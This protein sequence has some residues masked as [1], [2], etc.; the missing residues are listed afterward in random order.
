VNLIPKGTTVQ[1]PYSA[2]CAKSE[3]NI[4]DSKYTGK[5]KQRRKNMQE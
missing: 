5:V 3:T 1:M 4:K 2:A